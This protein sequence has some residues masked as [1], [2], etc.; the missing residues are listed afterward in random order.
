MPPKILSV[1]VAVI[2]SS[3]AEC[4]PIAERT[5]QTPEEGSALSEACNP[6]N[7]RSPTCAH[8]KSIK[9]LSRSLSNQLAVM[10]DLRQQLMLA[11]GQLQNALL[12]ASL[13]HVFESVVPSLHE[14]VQVTWSLTDLPSESM[15][16]ETKTSFPLESFWISAT[17]RV[18]LLKLSST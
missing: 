13:L 16:Y 2:P 10:D 3:A 12:E 11:F 17:K 14:Q 1:L 9:K 5:S 18:P 8:E 15:K 7:R 4:W 6:A